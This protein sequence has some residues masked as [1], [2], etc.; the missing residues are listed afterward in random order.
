MAPLYKPCLPSALCLQTERKQ[1][2]G[3]RFGVCLCFCFLFLPFFF[4]EADRFLSSRGGREGAS[5]TVQASKRLSSKACAQVLSD[6]C[7]EI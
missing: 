7:D 5:L 4:S 1:S 3:L 2:S 6:G